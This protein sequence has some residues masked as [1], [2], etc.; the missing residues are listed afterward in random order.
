MRATEPAIEK[1]DFSEQTSDFLLPQPAALKSLA[2]HLI[3]NII[4][5]RSLIRLSTTGM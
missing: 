4:I 5:N 3:L 2:G 1:I